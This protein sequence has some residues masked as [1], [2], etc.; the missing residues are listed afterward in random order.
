M[1]SLWR[2]ALP[3]SSG[4]DRVREAQV[5]TA[6]SSIGCGSVHAALNYDTLVKDLVSGKVD[7]AWAPPLVCAQIESA[8]GRV[9]LRA[10]RG[11]THSYRAVLF[12]RVDRDLTL[13][14]LQGK[15]AGWIDR[16]SMSGFVLPRG[17]LRAR[18][19]VPE[20]L[21]AHERFLGSFAACVQAVLDGK[22]DISSTYASGEAVRHPRLGFVELAGARAGELIDL[23]YSVD[24]PNDGIVLSPRL[25][26]DEDAFTHAFENLRRDSP[27][28]R[29]LAAALEV[30]DF[31]VPPA[32]SYQSLLTHLADPDP[33]APEASSGP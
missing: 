23:A 15:N 33:E 31:H 20:E 32:G 8:G 1:R 12:A 27:P 13:G 10:T 29:V 25:V 4:D 2:F 17:L 18:G 3:P 11:G 28:G 30:D 14:D 9:L 22:V 7:V 24:C 16:Q 21:F 26:E 6:L 5:R 19:M